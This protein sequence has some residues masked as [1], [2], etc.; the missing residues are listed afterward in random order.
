MCTQGYIQIYT[1]INSLS[2]LI[3]PFSIP[4]VSNLPKFQLAW[5]NTSFGISLRLHHDTT[6]V[7]MVLTLDVSGIRVILEGSALR[8]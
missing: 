5:F 2:H 6:L 3:F 8:L 1:H 4:R 7:P